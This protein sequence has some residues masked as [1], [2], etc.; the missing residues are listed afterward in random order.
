MFYEIFLDL[1][2]TFRISEKRTLYLPKIK[3]NMTNFL[4]KK[5]LKNFFK[6]FREGKR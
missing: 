4:A 3:K 1:K 2:I 6:C 5:N